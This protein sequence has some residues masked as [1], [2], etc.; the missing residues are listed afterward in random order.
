MAA[1]ERLGRAA[2]HDQPHRRAA[3]GDMKAVD[4]P[5]PTGA[6][7][8]ERLRHPG[9]YWSVTFDEGGRRF[10]WGE[11]EV[12][13]EEFREGFRPAPAAPAER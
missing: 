2:R 4:A 13:E 3:G 6:T 7:R 9:E 8:Q 10:W 1:E 5:P 12:D 11:I